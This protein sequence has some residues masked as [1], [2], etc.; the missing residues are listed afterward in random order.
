[1]RR[2]SG[3]R[4]PTPGSSPAPCWRRTTS[5]RVTLTSTSRRRTPICTSATRSSHGDL[6]A[7]LRTS[8]I[9]Y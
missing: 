6:M 4:S 2:P 7:Y 8:T 1:M 5:P 3:R 9:K